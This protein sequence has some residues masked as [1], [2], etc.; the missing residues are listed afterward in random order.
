VV[1]V[2]VV[3]MLM[4]GCGASGP[5]YDGADSAKSGREIDVADGCGLSVKVAVPDSWTV[6]NGKAA[7]AG[8]TGEAQYITLQCEALSGHGLS[9]LFVWE[10]S[11]GENVRDMR[12][13]LETFLGTRKSAHDMLYRDTQVDSKPSIEVTWL[14]ATDHRQRAFAYLPDDPVFGTLVVSVEGA[15]EDNVFEHD[16]LPA[17]LLAKQSIA[18]Q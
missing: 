3:G 2:A 11:V 13:V 18:P 8:D 1:G 15:T 7:P 6:R 10:K 14:G 12:K 9:G 16:L 4:A 17:Y 5:W